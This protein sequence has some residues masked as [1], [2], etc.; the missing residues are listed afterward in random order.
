MWPIGT[1]LAFLLPSSSSHVNGFRIAIVGLGLATLFLFSDG[2]IVPGGASDF[3]KWA[4]ALIDGST[5]PPA[6]SPR[7]VGFP[8][9]LV[10]SG[11]P[12]TGSFIGITII[13][14]G[15]AVLMPVF[16]YAALRPFS[17]AIAYYCGQIGNICLG[18]FQFVKMIHHD[19][20]YVFFTILMS[21]WIILFFARANYRYLY[22]FTI[23][24]V[25]ASVSRPAGNLLFPSFLVLAIVAS[26]R[27]RVIGHYIACATIFVTS[28]AS[29]QFYR[30]EV[31]DMGHQKSIPSYT[32]EQ[33]FYNLY[34]NSREYG[35]TLGPDIGPAMRQLDTALRDALGPVPQENDFL[36]THITPGLERFTAAAFLPF[37]RDELMQRI[38]LVPNWEYYLLLCDAAPSDQVMLRAAIEVAL[39]HPLYVLRY[40]MRNF[41]VFLFHPGYAHTRY[42]LNPFG[43]VRLDF[44][45]TLSGVDPSAAAGIAP[46]AVQEAKLQILPQEKPIFRELLSNL[47]AF[48]ERFWT[49]WYQSFVKITAILIVVSWLALACS[50]V[51]AIRRPRRGNAICE[52]VALWSRQSGFSAAALSASLPL[53]YNTA[54]T[55][56]FAEPDYRYHHF[57]LL[58]RILVAG[59]GAIALFRL[60]PKEPGARWASSTVW[61]DFKAL[62]AYAGQGARKG[63]SCD[64]VDFWLTV[65]PK[66]ATLIAL[67]LAAIA[68]GGWALFMLTLTA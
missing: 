22:L 37:T 43:P 11:Y 12:I 41:I 6:I 44:L 49:S 59:F 63:S 1:L 48:A 3:T 64:A 27:P 25:A 14:A 39:A 20:I 19:Q 34:Q 46:R 24:C 36:R 66:S 52:P 65:H 61:L 30:Y 58:V 8:L 55:A 47:D 42:N 16:V 45:P 62:V 60:L 7:D 53:L 28:I 56:A 21:M 35:I 29:Y 32:G 38:Y 67:S 10:L 23:A 40:S 4:D 50:A 57:I 2:Y 15:F 31:F 54:I 26:P 17:L 5:L 9:L 51:C 68:F 33:I 13:H 18:S